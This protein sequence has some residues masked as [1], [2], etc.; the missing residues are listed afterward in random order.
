MPSVQP[1]GVVPPPPGVTPN[2]VNPE[3]KYWT[4]NHAIVITGL[5]ISTSFL[6]MRLFTK[7]H[8]QRNFGFDDGMVFLFCSTGAENKLIVIRNSFYCRRL[9]ELIARLRPVPLAS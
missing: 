7:I 5:G 2:F 1:V 8:V 9:G 6:A 3:R 4:A